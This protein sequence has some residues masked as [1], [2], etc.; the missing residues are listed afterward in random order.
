MS[1]VSHGTGV[2]NVPNLLTIGRLLCVPIVLYLLLF[3]SGT[4]PIARDLA[5]GVFVLA[6]VTDFLDGRL[7]RRRHQVTAFGKFLDPI[8]DKALVGAALI[9]L[10]ILGHV[11]WWV[12]IVIMTREVVVTAVRFTHQGPLPVTPGAKAKTVTQ[13]IAITMYLVALPTI[14]WWST[15]AA[16]VMTIAVALTVITG[17]D[18]L[19][20]AWFP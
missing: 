17:L 5:A 7:A 19:R 12:T 15:A 10:S 3:E 4:N 20:R 11:P 18:Y 13:I 2:L 9:G 6:S 16:V 14:T 1:G 8:A